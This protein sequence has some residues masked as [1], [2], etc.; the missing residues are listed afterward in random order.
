MLSCCD[1]PMPYELRSSHPSRTIYARHF[2]RLKRPP[3]ACLQEEIQWSNEERHSFAFTIE[4]EADRLNRLVGN[5]LDMSRIEGGALVPEKELYPFDVLINDVLDRLSPLL[6]GRTVKTDLPEDLPPV[7]LDYLQIDQVL[8]NLLE[9]AVRYTPAD[10]P[11]D[12]SIGAQNDQIIISIA[13]RG[14]GIPADDLER[15]F[16]KFYRVQSGRYHASG[17]GLGLAVCKGLVEA[18]D[19]HIWAEPRSGGGVVFTITLPLAPIDI[20]VQHEQVHTLDRS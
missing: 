20:Q 10:K 12:I 11:I 16:D 14:P 8:T 18:H 6:Y 7:P 4:R 2:R 13:D 9:N 1:E 17:S 5:L 19:G 15:I 3:V